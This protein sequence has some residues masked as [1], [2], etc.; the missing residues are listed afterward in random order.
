MQQIKRIQTLR[1]TRLW[2][3]FLI[4]LCALFAGIT[5]R[6]QM[7][8]APAVPDEMKK[9]QSFVGE[10][11]NES[12]FINAEG[13]AAKKA[14]FTSVAA[15]AL[16]GRVIR[17]QSFHQDDPA[18]LSWFFFDPVKETFIL[19]GI[20]AWGHYDEFSGG[21]AGDTLVLTSRERMF[22]NGKKMMWRRTYTKITDQQH[23]IQMHY[24]LDGGKT[25]KLS[26]Q[27]VE[28]KQSPK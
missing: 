2:P 14:H 27:Q 7:P 25:W 26:N 4:A 6:A 19:V 10:W 3:T 5:G 9:L 17:F 12:T 1:T 11:N 8:T 28:T 20:D 13:E 16:D 22:P 23:H 21:F 24:S 15:P 18:G